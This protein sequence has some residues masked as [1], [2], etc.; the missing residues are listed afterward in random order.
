MPSGR[1]TD[2]CRRVDRAATAERS[3]EELRVVIAR[4]SQGERRRRCFTGVVSKRLP[5]SY[6]DCSV[7]VDPVQVR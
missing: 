5:K 2:V 7:D 6:A 1:S 4:E 3:S